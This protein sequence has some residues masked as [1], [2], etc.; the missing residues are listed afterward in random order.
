MAY[1]DKDKVCWRGTIQVDG[2]REQKLFPTKDE[3]S[4][5]E[6]QRKAYLE[7]VAEGNGTA[8]KDCPK[9]SDEWE[10]FIVEH[11]LSVVMSFSGK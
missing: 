10:A 3:A 9:T 1:F 7:E 6:K 5:W 4:L 8:K 11:F 2:Q